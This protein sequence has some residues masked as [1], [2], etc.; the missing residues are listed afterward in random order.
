MEHPDITWA[1]KTGYPKDYEEPQPY[2]CSECGKEVNEYIYR[3]R[4]GDIIG[5]DRCI[6]SQEYW[7]VTE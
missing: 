4:H 2:I 3:D 5:C 7:E 6:T 1:R